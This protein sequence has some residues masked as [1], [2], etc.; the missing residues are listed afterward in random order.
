MAR[1]PLA[2]VE[3]NIYQRS[4][5]HRPEIVEEWFALDS[6]MRFSGPLSP[7]LKEEVRRVL[8]PG[9]GC[10]FCASLGDADPEKRDRKSA[11]AVG[12]AQ[13]IFDNIKDLHSIDAEHFEVLRGEFTDAEVIELVCWTLF[14]IA[15]QGFGAIM[16]LPPATDDELREYT[17]WRA[18]GEKDAA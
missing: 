4:M 14:M 12:F 9:I 13:T 5:G 17:V 3:G 2:D 15:A 1:I 16:K 10:T 18:A 7:G 8:A 6:L 11:L